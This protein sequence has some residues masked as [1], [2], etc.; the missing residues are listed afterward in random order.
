MLFERFQLSAMSHMNPDGKA[1]NEQMFSVIVSVTDRRFA[2]AKKPPSPD[3]AALNMSGGGIAGFC[4]TKKLA[5]Y[6]TIRDING[7]H[8]LANT[9]SG[10]EWQP[11]YHR[12]RH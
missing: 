6:R 8:P 9:Y 4:A 3:V 5:P 1:Q 7:P 2:H 12:P 10:S 11:A